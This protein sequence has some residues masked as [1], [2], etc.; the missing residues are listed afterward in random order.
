MGDITPELLQS[1]GKHS[2]KWCSIL[3]QPITTPWVA[4]IRFSRNEI[5]SILL[6]NVVRDFI[7]SISVISQDC[8]VGDI[9]TEQKILECRII[10]D[11]SFLIG[12]ALRP[13]VQ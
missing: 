12:Y 2:T 7:G 6:L 11:S 4:C 9:K 8:T 5:T 13:E 10:L 1:E 3:E